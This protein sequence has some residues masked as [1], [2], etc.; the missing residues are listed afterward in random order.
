MTSGS[1]ANICEIVQLRR[2][3]LLRYKLLVELPSTD[4]I[5]EMTPDK[6]QKMEEVVDGCSISKAPSDGTQKVECCWLDFCIIK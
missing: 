6:C 2:L 5:K 1:K 4:N 3:V